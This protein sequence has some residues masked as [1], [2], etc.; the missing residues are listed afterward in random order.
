[1]GRRKTFERGQV[2]E[3]QREP[4]ATWERATYR[5][6]S[7]F[8]GSTWHQTEVGY[9]RWID[10]M[11]GREYTPEAVAAMPSTDPDRQRLFRTRV[12]SV[13]ARRIRAVS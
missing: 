3:I 6:R 4:G 2:V 9:D 11:S 13:P 10:S 7:N 8:P 12:L 5:G 1:M